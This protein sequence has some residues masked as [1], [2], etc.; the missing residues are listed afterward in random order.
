MLVNSLYK[1]CTCKGPYD[2]CCFGFCIGLDP[3][4]SV[5]V[6]CCIGLCCVFKFVVVWFCFPII[7]WFLH[8]FGGCC[9]RLVVCALVFVF[10]V[11]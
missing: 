7:L 5:L 11:G 9:I 3:F 6:V 4:A 8:A 2:F 1:L 10:R